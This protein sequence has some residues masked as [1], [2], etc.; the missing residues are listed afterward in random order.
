VRS[1]PD[2][3]VIA[4]TVYLRRDMIKVGTVRNSTLVDLADLGLE[5]CAALD[6]WDRMLESDDELTAASRRLRHAQRAFRDALGIGGEADRMIHALRE[7]PHLAPSAQGQATPTIARV[8]D[9]AP[10]MPPGAQG[11]TP[12]PQAPCPY[13]GHPQAE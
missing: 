8:K 12:Q 9:Q 13:C 6:A 7:T 5:F 11:P 2:P 1:P 4:G 10:Q 3:G